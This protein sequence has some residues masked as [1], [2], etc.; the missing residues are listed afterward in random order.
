MLK[1]SVTGDGDITTL[2]YTIKTG[3]LLHEATGI[4]LIPWV[5]SKLV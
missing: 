5:N 3:A 2:L 4:R 1:K